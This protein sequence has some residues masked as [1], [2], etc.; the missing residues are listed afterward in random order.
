M[1]ALLWLYDNIIFSLICADLAREVPFAGFMASGLFAPTGGM[2]SARFYHT[3]TSLGSSGQVLVAG[4]D[5]SIGLNTA[6]L[7]Q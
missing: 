6:E 1:A 7:Y 4:G 5:N 3:M 2:Q